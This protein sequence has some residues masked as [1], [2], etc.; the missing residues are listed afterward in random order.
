[1]SNLVVITF[2]N[3]AEAGKVRESIRRLEHGG[4][5]ELHRRTVAVCWQL[6]EAS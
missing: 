1:M 3:E 5:K 6:P 4:R 2:D